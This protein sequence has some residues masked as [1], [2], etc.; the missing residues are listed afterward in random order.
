[1]T[2]GLISSKARC[3]TVWVMLRDLF[4]RAKSGGRNMRSRVSYDDFHSAAFL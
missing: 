4:G 3:I 1:M 2:L